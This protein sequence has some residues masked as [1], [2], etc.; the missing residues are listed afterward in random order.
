MIEVFA[1]LA[2]FT[3]VCFYLSG[4]IGVLRFATVFCRLHAVTKA[5]NLGL[6]MIMLGLSLLS[7]SLL[8]AIKAFL[9]WVLVLMCSAVSSSLIGRYAAAEE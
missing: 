4:S 3:G 1:W 8:F 5:D 7:S 6:G 2:I 9:I